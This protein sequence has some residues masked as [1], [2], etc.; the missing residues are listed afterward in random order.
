METVLGTTGTGKTSKF[1]VLTIFRV[2]L[3]SS[4]DAVMLQCNVT[5]QYEAVASAAVHNTSGTLAGQA[6][7]LET[8]PSKHGGVDAEVFWKMFFPYCFE[9]SLV[10]PPR[11]LSDTRPLFLSKISQKAVN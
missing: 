8:Q 10:P 11:R 3:T 5:S 7:T 9:F 1:Q 6:H 2:E 4:S